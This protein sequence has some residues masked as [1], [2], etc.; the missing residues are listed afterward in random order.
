MAKICMKIH[1]NHWPN[2]D[3]HIQPKIN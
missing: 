1:F 3:V 2:P